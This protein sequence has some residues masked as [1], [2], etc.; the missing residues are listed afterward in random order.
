VIIAI[1]QPNY[2]PWLGYFQKI[3]IADTFIF[4]DDAQYSK[5]SYTNRVQILSGDESRWLTIPAT[6]RFG[7]PI[8]A[9][10]A[11]KPGWVRSHLDQLR[12]AY[13]NAP[14]FS[15][16][17][18]W[19]RGVYD[20]VEE[21]ADLASINRTLVETVADYLNLDCDFVAASDQDIGDRTGDDR[22]VALVQ[23]VDPRGIYL[24]GSGGANYQNEEKFQAA[25]LGLEY[26]NFFHPQ[27][28]QGNDEFMI[29]LS[30]L[31]ALFH[32][33]REKT[34]AMLRQGAPGK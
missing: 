4:L 22:L 30:T 6:Y 31:D 5:N 28:K 23:G 7:D 10:H 12:T 21:L 1:H 17:W 11:T 27:Y 34:A 15:E 14:A 3:L 24:S 13:G 33:G 32:T 18:E 26:G 29:G 2:F 19:I 16:T 25:K 20:N 9:V 8:N